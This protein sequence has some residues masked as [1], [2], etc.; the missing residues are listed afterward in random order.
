MEYSS[1]P[2]LLD[3]QNT[4]IVYGSSRNANFICIYDT[5]C[6]AVSTG[7]CCEICQGITSTPLW[8]YIGALAGFATSPVRYSQARTLTRY[9]IRFSW[10]KK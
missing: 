3:N 5:A 10:K 8:L 7:I 9:N 6:R 2:L 1:S 4:Y